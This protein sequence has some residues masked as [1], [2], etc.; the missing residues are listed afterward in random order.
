VF[1]ERGFANTT[2]EDIPAAADVSRRTFFRYYASKDDLLRVDVADLLPTMQ[3]ALRA[4]PLDEPELTSIR[5]ALLMLIGPAG[6]PALAASLAGSVSGLRARLGLLRLL[7][8]WEQGIAETLLARRGLTVATAGEDDRLRT[9]VIACAATSALRSSAQVYRSR[10]P[11][12]GLQTE[13]LVA[14]LE[15]AFAVLAASGRSA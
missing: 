12:P 1:A 2:I 13:N 3:A 11:G 7:A 10:Y 14:I 15:Q 9:V 8:E 6:P 4:R 5:A